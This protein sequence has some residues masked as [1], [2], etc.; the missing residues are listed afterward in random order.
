MTIGHIEAGGLDHLPVSFGPA[1]IG[2]VPPHQLFADALVDAGHHDIDAALFEQNIVAAPL[3]SGAG[4]RFWQVDLSPPQ[5]GI[6]SGAAFDAAPA[7]DWDDVHALNTTIGNAAQRGVIDPTASRVATIFSPDG[8]EHL[9]LFLKPEPPKPPLPLPIS[10]PS[11]LDI[12]TRVLA[13]AGLVLPSVLGIGHAESKVLFHP[14]DTS[15]I[16]LPPSLDLGPLMSAPLTALVGG[17]ASA[18]MGAALTAHFPQPETLSP[19]ADPPPDGMQAL[20][21]AVQAAVDA[22]KQAGATIATV[23]AGAAEAVLSAV[24][25]CWPDPEAQQKALPTVTANN[26]A[27]A[28]TRAMVDA[29]NKGVNTPA[30][31]RLLAVRREMGSVFSAQTGQSPSS[32]SIDV[33]RATEKEL[34]GTIPPRTVLQDKEGALYVPFYGSD[35]KLVRLIPVPSF[36]GNPS[37]I[38]WD[39]EAGMVQV[40][41]FDKRAAVYDQTTGMFV[42]LGSDVELTF[43]PNFQKFLA[44]FSRERYADLEKQGVRDAAI[45]LRMFKAGD[46]AGFIAEVVGPQNQP[47]SA[48]AMRRDGRFVS[49]PEPDAG[50]EWYAATLGIFFQRPKGEDRKAQQPGDKVFDPNEGK[51][52]Q[53]SVIPAPATAT[54]EPTAQPTVAPTKEPPKPTPTPDNRVIPQPLPPEAKIENYTYVH[55]PETVEYNGRTYD[56]SLPGTSIEVDARNFKYHEIKFAQ[57][58]GPLT[59]RVVDGKTQTVINIQ[60]NNTGPHL[61]G[62]RTYNWGDGGK[63]SV[64]VVFDGSPELLRGRVDLPGGGSPWITAAQIKEG[65]TITVITDGL[66]QNLG[67]F[68]LGKTVPKISFFRLQNNVQIDIL[69]SSLR[70]RINS[71]LQAPVL[72]P[73]SP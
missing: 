43:G 38:D 15:L 24:S 51:D 61:I 6:S 30:T 20:K 13:A 45:L 29:M 23:A 36:G 11:P 21:D 12:A 42:L 53:Q 39:K 48:W 5:T 9:A 59:T 40:R 35:N 26:N 46:G 56:L 50:M 28:E 31:R 71:R 19:P 57:V 64:Q 32:A 41:F 25:S 62:I 3:D 67:S 65:T 16:P 52:G 44:T 4:F 55:Q 54:P 58:V 27:D 72:D 34:I 49:L 1:D 7:H 69:K 8:N 10:T 14:S 68:L 18:M 63:Y 37:S 66:I 22:A 47:H 73:H 17:E 60:I 70:D 2:S 33:L